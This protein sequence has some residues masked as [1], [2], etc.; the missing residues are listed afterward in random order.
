MARITIEDIIKGTVDKMRARRTGSIT[1]VVSL[2]NNLWKLN[3]ACTFDIAA[4]QYITV[5]P[6]AT[7]FKV[8]TVV[9]NVSITVLSTVSLATQTSW[10]ATAPLFFYGNPIDANQEISLSQQ[11]QNKNYPAV[12]LF[13]VERETYDT[14]VISVNDFTSECQ[15]FFMDIED[16]HGKTIAQLYQGTVDR[17]NEL[18][19]EFVAKLRKERG[20]NIIDD[21]GVLSKHSKWGVRVVRD[22]R[23]GSDTIFDNNLSGVELNISVPVR[24]VLNQKCK[25]T[26]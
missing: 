22:G 12:I 3:V 18:A 7:T 11:D 26:C 19:I 24:K 21:T 16:H 25:T 2:G 1:S 5:S 9:A 17:M 13:E 10:A 6:L 20:V 8:T 4:G 23:D 15:I 14:D